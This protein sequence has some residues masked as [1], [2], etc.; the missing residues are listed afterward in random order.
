MMLGSGS[1][2]GVPKNLKAK[3]EI[4]EEESPSER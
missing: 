3:K 2:M 1:D 4:R